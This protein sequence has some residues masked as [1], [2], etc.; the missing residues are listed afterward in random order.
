MNIGFFPK[1]L[2]KSDILL[3]NIK[4]LLDIGGGLNP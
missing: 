2:I 1:V 3:T 4:Y